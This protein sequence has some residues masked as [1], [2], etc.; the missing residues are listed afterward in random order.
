LYTPRVK[1][2]HHAMSDV[3]TV[4]A[5]SRRNPWSVW[6]ATREGTACSVMASAGTG[7]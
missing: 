2:G 4:M 6:R 5:A 7:S 1:A 3:A